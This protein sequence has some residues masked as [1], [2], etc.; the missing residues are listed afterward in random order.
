MGGGT[1]GGFWTQVVSDV[2]GREQAGARAD[3][4]CLLRRRAH[5]GDRRRAG[6]ARHRLDPRRPHRR[7]RARAPR[8]CTTRC[9]PRTKSLYPATLQQVHALARLQSAT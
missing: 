2:T 3:D 8:A 9:T 7:A 6:A 4:R 5:G 1:Q